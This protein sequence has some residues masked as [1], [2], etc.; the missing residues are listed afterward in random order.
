MTVE[1]SGEQ[2]HILVCWGRAVEDEKM[3]A[4][5]RELLERLIVLRDELLPA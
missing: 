4:A 1:L 5:E 3:T 2:L